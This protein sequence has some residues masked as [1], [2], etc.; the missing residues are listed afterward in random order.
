MKK[1]SGQSM[2]EYIL[3]LVAVVVILLAFLSPGGSFSK[4]IGGSI[5]KI[6]GYVGEK[7]NK[8]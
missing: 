8:K 2:I 6:V 7:L 4:K 5:D 3:V 1:L